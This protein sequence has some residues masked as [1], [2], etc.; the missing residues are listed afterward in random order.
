MF[1][2]N[3]EN[4]IIYAMKCYNS[5]TCL[6]SE[7][8]EDFKRV[9]YIKRL[10]GKYNSSGE[11][12]ERLILNHIIVMANV[13]GVEGTVRLLFLKIDPKDY[14]ILKTFLTYLSYMPKTVLSICGADIGSNSITIDPNVVRK[15]QSI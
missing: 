14:H 10:I 4:A 2:L 9:K 12:R 1:D 3:H 6:M 15:L 7:F 8:E 5:P 13:F 11:L